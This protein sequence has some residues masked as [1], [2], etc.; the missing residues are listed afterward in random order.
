MCIYIILSKLMCCLVYPDL[1]FRGLKLRDTETLDSYGL[2]DGSTVYII[3][4]QEPSVSEGKIG[5]VL[6]LVKVFI[7][8]RHV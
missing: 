5:T 8:P 2:K 6:Q 3:Y 4:K 1:I 7:R